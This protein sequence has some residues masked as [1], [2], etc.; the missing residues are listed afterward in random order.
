MA[1]R[2]EQNPNG[3]H[4]ILSISIQFCLSALIVVASL[5]RLYAVGTMALLPLIFDAPAASASHIQNHY[6]LLCFT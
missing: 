3:E 6:G 2:Q 1:P 5:A 4:V